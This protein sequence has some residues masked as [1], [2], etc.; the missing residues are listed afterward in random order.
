ML[1]EP[2][3]DDRGL[4]AGDRVVVTNLEDVAE[5]SRLRILLPTNAED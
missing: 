1:A 4:Q 3:E 5:G 2:A